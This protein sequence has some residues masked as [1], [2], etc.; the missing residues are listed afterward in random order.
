MEGA[1]VNR[2]LVGLSALAAVLGGFLVVQQLDPFSAG[3]SG[4]VA[5]V[6]GATSQQASA[7]KL[8]PLQDLDP[9]SF[10]DVVE[11]PLFNPSRLPRPAEPVAPP[12]PPEPPAVQQPP[13][14]PPVPQGPGP[15][16]YKLLGVSSGPDGRIAALR[17]ASSGDVVYLRKG[18]SVDGWSVLDLSD[19]SIAIGPPESPVTY[20]LFDSSE[21]ASMPED[22]QPAVPPQG[23]PLPLPLPLPMP[24][25][26]P[27]PQ[28]GVPAL[29]E[30]H[31]LPDTGG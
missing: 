28:P 31:S 8:N 29:P 27:R 2:R 18:E 11:K 10:P 1:T 17:V 26:Q 21:E 7:V 4:D 16:D 20:S 5:P 9:E 22:G 25:Q 24:A 13:P 6:A 19:R 15:E 12:P 3:G 30:Q 14:P 23:Q